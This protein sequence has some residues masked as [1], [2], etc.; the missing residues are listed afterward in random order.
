MMT[1]C[2]TIDAIKKLNPTADSEFL[3]EFTGDDLN[4]YLVRLT[5]LPVTTPRYLAANDAS[6]DARPL[7]NVDPKKTLER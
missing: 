2:D 6:S 5:D 1:K 4:A 7:P 3:A